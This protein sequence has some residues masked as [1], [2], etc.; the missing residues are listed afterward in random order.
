MK[1]AFP[2]YF[3]AFSSIQAENMEGGHHLRDLSVSGKIILKFIFKYTY[4]ILSGL[5]WLTTGTSSGLL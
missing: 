4:G 3:Q 2:V 5:T 1:L